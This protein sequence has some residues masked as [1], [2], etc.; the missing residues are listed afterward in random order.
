M[1]IHKRTLSHISF[2]VSVKV[3]ERGAFWKKA[4]LNTPT[5]YTIHNAAIS[6]RFLSRHIS[7]G[8]IEILLSISREILKARYL[9][10][11][12]GDGMQAES[13]RDISPARIGF[14]EFFFR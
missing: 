14:R 7:T 2:P 13:K 1:H 11:A 8:V 12:D 5:R 10:S 6:F 3:N 9:D 4:Q